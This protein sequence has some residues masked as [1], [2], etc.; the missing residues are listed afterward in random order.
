MFVD[1]YEIVKTYQN[2]FN[3]LHIKTLLSKQ[4]A[5]HFQVTELARK[6]CCASFVMLHK[7]SNENSL[8]I[9]KTIREDL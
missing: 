6:V 1:L 2:G 9:C 8:F 3:V 4:H 7:L 5:R